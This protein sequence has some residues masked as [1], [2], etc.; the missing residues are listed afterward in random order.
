MKGLELSYRFYKEHG[1]PMLPLILCNLLN[2][3]HAT[4]EKPRHFLIDLID[5]ASC[6]F[7]KIHFC[8]PLPSFLRC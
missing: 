6:L 5:D 7:Q 2:R 8:A 4:H 1:E 3:L